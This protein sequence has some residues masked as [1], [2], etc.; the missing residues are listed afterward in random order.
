[1]IVRKKYSCNT[2]IYQSARFISLATGR[3]FSCR[4]SHHSSGQFATA[5]FTHETSAQ[6]SGKKV[7]TA[8]FCQDGI[9]IMRFFHKTLLFEKE[10]GMLKN[11]LILFCPQSGYL[12]CCLTLFS[13]QCSMQLY[14][15]GV[16]VLVPLSFTT[17]CLGRE[18]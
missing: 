6:N 2:V 14:R 12:M 16:V 17:V 10:V 3:L 7:L 8:L 5:N 4:E 13:K 9:K 1:M 18:L 11:K 15:S